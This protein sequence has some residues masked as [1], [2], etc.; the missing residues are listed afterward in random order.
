MRNELQQR[1][2]S[3]YDSWDPPPQHSLHH[4]HGRRLCQPSKAAEMPRLKWKGEH[5]QL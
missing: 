3:D 5:E 2:Q 1:M 4:L